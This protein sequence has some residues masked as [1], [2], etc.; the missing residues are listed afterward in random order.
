MTSY[1]FVV[2][3]DPVEGKEEEYNNWYDNVHLKEVT[4]CDGF[5]A[6]T[7]YRFKPL[8]GETPPRQYMAIYDI[9]S[10]DVLA[11]MKNLMDR[12]LSG[13]MQM[14]DALAP[15]PITYLFEAMPAQGRKD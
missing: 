15:N 13:G 5:V 3:T 2:F 7:R 4:E 1:K 8:D 14:S 11:T 6:A 9:E 10:G 12:A